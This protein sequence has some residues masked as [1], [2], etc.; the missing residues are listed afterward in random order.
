MIIYVIIFID[1]ITYSIMI[2]KLLH[3]PFFHHSQS[4]F[5]EGRVFLPLRWSLRSPFPTGQQWSRISQWS[6]LDLSLGWFELT[7]VTVE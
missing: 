5:W 4:L 3:D 7:T 2:M 6:D 1:V